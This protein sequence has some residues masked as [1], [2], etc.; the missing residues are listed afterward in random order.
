MR[1]SEKLEKE[2]AELREA[3]KQAQ[4]MLAAISAR[5]K[6]MKEKHK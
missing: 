3:L 4:E 2:N 6:V 1:T 5:V